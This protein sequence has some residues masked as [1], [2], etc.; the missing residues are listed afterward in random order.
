MLPKGL[1]LPFVKNI[2]IFTNRIVWTTTLSYAIQSSP[3]IIANNN[4]VFTLNSSA[5]YDAAKNLRL[6]FNVGLQRQ[7]DKYL[8]EN[9]FIS[10]QAGSTLTFQF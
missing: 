2:I 10:Y 4:R 8:K 9:D 6:T 5:D 1:K 3:I 7:W